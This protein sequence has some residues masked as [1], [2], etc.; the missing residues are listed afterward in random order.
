M[1]EIARD[2]L[3]AGATLPGPPTSQSWGTW[4]FGVKHDVLTLAGLTTLFIKRVSGSITPVERV[5][6]VRRQLRGNVSANAALVISS[7]T[8]K[9]IKAGCRSNRQGIATANGTLVTIFA[10]EVIA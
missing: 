3:G 2:R 9:H 5:A 4:R 7:P 6:C 8:S 1:D 10:R